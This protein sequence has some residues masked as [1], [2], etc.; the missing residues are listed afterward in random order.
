MPFIS[1]SSLL[2]GISDTWIDLLQAQ[3]SLL[4]HFAEHVF[5]LLVQDSALYVLALHF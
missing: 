1:D 3:P 5:V 4:S 2:P